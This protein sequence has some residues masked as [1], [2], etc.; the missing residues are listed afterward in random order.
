MRTETL[1]NYELLSR[2]LKKVLF[3]VKFEMPVVPLGKMADENHVNDQTKDITSEDLSD[4]PDA[5]IAANLEE[6]IFDDPEAKAQFEARFLEYDETATFQYLKSFRRARINF[7]SS[8]LAVNA[9]IRLHE[10]DMLGR[11]MKCYFAQ[12]TPKESANSSTHL[13]PPPLEKQFLI[14]P[15]ASPPVGWEQ[16]REKE[17]GINFDLITA[18]AELAP[19]EAHELHPQSESQPGIVVHIC[20]DP[21]GFKD[22]DRLRIVQTKRP[23]T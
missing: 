1:N 9:R 6:R 17:P 20:E 10:I 14:S 8:G 12:S 18:I 22:P 5:L 13:H 11:T 2:A 15:P 21:E 3:F 23:Q 16:M 19:G 4:L 7:S